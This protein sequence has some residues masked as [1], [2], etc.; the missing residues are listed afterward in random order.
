MHKKVRSALFILF[1]ALTFVI[2]LSS[3]A[4]A[5]DVLFNGRALKFDNDPIVVNGA[6]LV[7][8]RPLAEAF[9]ATVKW[10]PNTNSV[11]L[12]TKKSGLVLKIDYDIMTKTD[13]GDSEDGDFEQ[14]ALSAAPR[15]VN[16]VAYVPVRDI[17]KAFGASVDWD[18][19]SGNILISSGGYR[20]SS[21]PAASPVVFR[22]G[23][24]H[25]FFFQNQADWSLPNYGSGYCW[26]C[27]YAMLITDVT[28]NVVTPK[29]VA[30]VNE[31][32][33]ASGSY[34][35][36]GDIVSKFGVKFVSALD[37]NSPYYGGRDSVAGGTK[38]LNPGKDESVTIAAIKEALD[39]HPEGI[40]VRYSSYPH[41]LVAV[42]YE[43]DTIYFNEPM[44]YGKGYN[45][46]SV[47]NHITFD[48]TCVGMRGM[49]IADVTYLQAL[50]KA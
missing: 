29:D 42:G 6:T 31:S 5:N 38:I 50:A 9:D 44:P 30:A 1:S 19:E 26:T 2:C 47:Y 20:Y 11:K 3:A 32:K 17:S 24:S 10:S 16:N 40:M 14:V 41:T 46:S 39:L 36:H 25:T 33:G 13:L 22:N 4:S 12:T 23:T 27:C 7:E 18:G 34:C 8:V 15:L 45:D 28:G 43:G 21:A 49:S 48:E 37:E 35:Y